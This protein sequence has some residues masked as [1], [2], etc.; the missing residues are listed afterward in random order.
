MILKSFKKAD[1]S[2]Y[3]RDVLR[4][5]AN[6]P[7]KTLTA[8]N[9]EIWEWCY[10]KGRVD[11]DSRDTFCGSLQRATS[12]LQKKIK[13]NE[14]HG[15]DYE[16]RHKNTNLSAAE[17]ELYHGFVQ[18]MARIGLEMTPKRLRLLACEMF[19]D[20]GKFGKIWS[21]FSSVL[22]VVIFLISHF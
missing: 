22:R 20:H 18:G 4:L 15:D 9:G 7:S 3:A 21:L 12:R 17:E 16:V 10:N 6:D 13:E 1:F 2:D 11:R 8:I 5:R 14:A 19:P